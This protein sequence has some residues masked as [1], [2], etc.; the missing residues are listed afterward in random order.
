MDEDL[1]KKR[2]RE[3]SKQQA[4]YVAYRERGHK[5]Q[6]SA[7]MAG[8]S[9]SPKSGYEVEK[10]EVVQ[11]ELAR[12][13]KEIAETTGVTREQVVKGMLEAADMAKILG[14]PQAMVRA[15]SEI[16]KLHGFYAP[17]IKKHVH[18][19]DRESREALKRLSDVE[20]RQ[21]AHGRVIEG[22]STPVDTEESDD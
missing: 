2:R 9:A 18:G 12:A 3:L 16:G 11:E 17:E 8:Y 19:I 4:M 1:I 10:S 5:K 15:W 20:L 22:E 21:L 14:D 7:I 13:R 6:Q